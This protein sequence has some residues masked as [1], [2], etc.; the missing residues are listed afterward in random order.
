M[1]GAVSYDITGLI[2]PNNLFVYNNLVV[3]LITYGTFASPINTCFRNG[4]N[5][6][7]SYM[8]AYSDPSI[9]Q[10]Q[11]IND[12]TD[13]I[14]N[15]IVAQENQLTSL[16][17]NIQNQFNN[18]VNY[19]QKSEKISQSAY[20]NV[21]S[22]Y[23]YAANMYSC[24]IKF[25]NNWSTILNN[26]FQRLWNCYFP[27]V[28]NDVFSLRI[29]LYNQCYKFSSVLTPVWLGISSCNL[30]QTIQD[31]RD[32][33]VNLVMFKLIFFKFSIKR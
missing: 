23:Q 22:S 31:K 33:I 27:N 19:A 16:Q 5:Y 7:P 13:R 6:V 3:P 2:Y 10:N 28:I 24:Y 1:G 25:N 32:C 18:Y 21:Q 11:T 17:A 30:K 20:I 9:L 14:L 29:A 12:Y 8:R 4:Y 26:G 15:Q